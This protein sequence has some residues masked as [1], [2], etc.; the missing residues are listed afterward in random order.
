M[1]R[2]QPFIPIIVCGLSAF[3]RN[4]RSRRMARDYSKNCSTDLSYIRT[5]LRQARAPAFN[6]AWA[7]I[8]S[9]SSDLSRLSRDAIEAER[10][11]RNL[12]FRGT[13][14]FRRAMDAIAHRR[15]GKSCVVEEPNE[16][17]FLDGAK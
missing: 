7:R 11:A 8:V 10:T 5:C 15:Q 12:E 4:L 9:F 13:A 1:L 17:T 6:Q 14:S 2:Q 3:D 16:R